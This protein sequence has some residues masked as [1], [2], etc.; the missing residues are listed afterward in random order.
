M[1]HT[2]WYPEGRLN[3][4]SWEIFMS[5]NLVSNSDYVPADIFC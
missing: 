4:L 2:N 1:H 3:V 5:A